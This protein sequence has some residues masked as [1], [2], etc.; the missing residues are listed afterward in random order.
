MA[1]VDTV[2]DVMTT[3]KVAMRPPQQYDVIIYNDTTTTM[4]FVILVLMSIFQKS[5]EDATTL[6]LLIDELGLG[7][8]GTYSYEIATQKRDDTINA[9][10]INGFQLKCQVA[11]V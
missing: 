10:R 9:A 3:T 4:E 5:F 8:A 2:N 11:P 6:T 7:V 1:T